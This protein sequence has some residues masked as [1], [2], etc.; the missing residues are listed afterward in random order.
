MADKDF[1]KDLP[2][3]PSI[4]E[5]NFSEQMPIMNINLSGDFS[6]DQLKEYSEHLEDV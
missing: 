2:T 5:M 6:M 4:T 3:E 1:P